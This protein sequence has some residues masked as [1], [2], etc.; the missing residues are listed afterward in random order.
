MSRWERLER[1]S[2]WK[3]SRLRID[4]LPNDVVLNIISFL[5]HDDVCSLL[6]ALYAVSPQPIDMR[7]Q[8]QQVPVELRGEWLH[9]AACD[10]VRR[11]LYGIGEMA[12]YHSRDCTR[13]CAHADWSVFS[14][15][16]MPVALCVYEWTPAHSARVEVNECEIWR[17]VQHASATGRNAVSIALYRYLLWSGSWILHPDPCYRTMYAVFPHFL[18]SESR[19]SGWSWT[20]RNA[21]IGD[22]PSPCVL[23]PPRGN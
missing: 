3:Q 2:R 15:P 4:R 9:G 20:D 8:V 22:T 19:Y 23:A 10:G 17:V 18:A 11:M 6:N 16:C 1:Y 13:V 21:R 14:G 5:A 7:R 12:F